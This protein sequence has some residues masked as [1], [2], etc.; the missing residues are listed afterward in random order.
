MKSRYVESK[1]EKWW[2]VGAPPSVA[3]ALDLTAR[4]SRYLFRRRRR[5]AILRHFTP[6]VGPE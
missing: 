1:R 5:P 4:A 2:K 3:N 6:G